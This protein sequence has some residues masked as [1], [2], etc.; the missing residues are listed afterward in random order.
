MFLLSLAIE[1][2]AQTPHGSWSNL[3]RLKVGQ[4]IEVIESNM[5]RHAG[6][7]SLSAMDCSP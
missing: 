5:K 3:N 6:S 4:G 1:L 7:L 2:G